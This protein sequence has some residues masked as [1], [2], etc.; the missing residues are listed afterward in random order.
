MG[1]IGAVF[2]Q[3]Q[4]VIAVALAPKDDVLHCRRHGAVHHAGDHP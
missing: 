1:E 4:E 3:G 2:F